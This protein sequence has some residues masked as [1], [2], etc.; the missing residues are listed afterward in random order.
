MGTRNTPTV[1][2]AGWQDAQF[3]DGRAEDLVE[4]AGQPILNP[5]EMGMPDEKAVVDKIRGIDEYR[6]GFAEAFPGAEP[7][8]TY[9]NIAEAIAAFERTLITPGRFD[10]FLNGDVDALSEAEQQGLQTYLKLDCNSC[11]DGILLGGE[12]YEPLGKE[13]PYGNQAD[14]GIYEL[15]GLEEDRMFFKV[16]PLRNVAL[17]APYFHDGRIATLEEAVRKMGKL[18]LD[19]ELSDQQVNDVTAFLRTLTDKNREQ[20][21]K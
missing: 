15:T 9:Q 11:H 18:Q 5:I 17:T 8:I 16:A 20:Y 19:L 21:L 7:A 6:D 13:H 2:N 3:W 4:Q 1:L 14:Q 10:D 12:T